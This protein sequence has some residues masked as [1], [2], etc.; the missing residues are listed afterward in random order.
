[1][2]LQITDNCQ[3]FAYLFTKAEILLSKSVRI[4][5]SVI[6]LPSSVM[7]AN[8]RPAV[9]DGTILRVP[10]DLTIS[11][12]RGLRMCDASFITTSVQ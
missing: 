12:L 1:M 6:L 11:G 3:D 9:L 2:F 8:T 10:S 4:Y 5:G 7:S